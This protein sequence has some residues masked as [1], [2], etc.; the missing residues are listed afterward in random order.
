MKRIL[1]GIL[2]VMALAL[3]LIPALTQDDA[4]DP[5]GEAGFLE[6]DISTDF[7]I[8]PF[9]ISVVAGGGVDVVPLDLDPECVGNVAPAPDARVNLAIDDTDDTLLRIMFVS[10]QD[11]TLVIQTPD[12]AFICNDDSYVP[13]AEAFSPS[14]DIQDPEAGTYNIWVGTF[15]EG[16]FAP[17]YLMLTE[18]EETYPGQVASAILGDVILPLEDE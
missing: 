2:V 11:T 5:D 13:G 1:V 17:G 8:D 7:V 10:E 12:G 16:T 15:E 14:V 3:L 9:I 6:V 4:L 18:D